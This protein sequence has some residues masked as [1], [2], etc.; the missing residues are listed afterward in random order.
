MARP[1][2]FDPATVAGAAARVFRRDGYAGASL[3]ALTRE[4]GLGR[5]SLYAAFRDKRALFL[6]ALDD[7]A[8]A[9]LGHVERTLAV[10]ADPLE[11]IEAVLRRVAVAATSGDGRHGCLVA[12]SAAELAGRDA[13]VRERVASEFARIE[14]AFA[15]ALARGAGGRAT[16]R[17]LVAVMQGLRILGAAGAERAAL[18][19]V[20]EETMRAVRGTAGSVP[21]GT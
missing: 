10:A 2:T 19:E 6:A 4:T 12:N 7:Y 11:G 20:V 13:E 16:A 15:D 17:L 21:A 3:S 18:D 8:R 9:M 14:T 5:G 1:R